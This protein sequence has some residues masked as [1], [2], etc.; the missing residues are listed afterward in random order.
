MTSVIGKSDYLTP[1][2]RFGW[3]TPWVA[4]SLAALCWLWLVVEAVREKIGERRMKAAEKQRLK[5][6]LLPEA[7][8]QGAP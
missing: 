8:D 3:L 1:Y 2:T 6:A 4:L 7:R 5:D